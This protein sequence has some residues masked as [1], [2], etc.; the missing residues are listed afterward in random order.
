MNSNLCDR[1]ITISWHV[2]SSIQRS[3]QLFTN[4]L[5]KQSALSP[6]TLYAY[7]L[8]AQKNCLIDGSIVYP[9]H[10]YM[11]YVW[12]MHRKN[13]QILSILWMRDKHVVLHPLVRLRKCCV[14]KC[15]TAW[16]PENSVRGVLKTFLSST[17]FTDLPRQLHLEAGGGIPTSI[18]KGIYSNF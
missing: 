14:N 17:Y 18:S 4:N 12:L 10:T 3:S 6:E 13:N 16:H 8:G 9:Q 15:T 11:L 7:D 1:S 5:W 2:L